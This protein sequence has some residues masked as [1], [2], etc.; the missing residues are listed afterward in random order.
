MENKVY[1]ALDICNL[2]LAMLGESPID[3]IDPNG[4]RSQRLCYTHYHPA[5]REVLLYTHLWSFAEHEVEITSDDETG[6]KGHSIPID[7]LRILKVNAPDWFLMDCA[8]Q[9][10]EKTI[11]LTYI[12]DEEDVEKFEDA[13][14]E[15]FVIRLAMK[16][17]IPLTASTKIYQELSNKYHELSNNH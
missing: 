17:C 2:A 12:A 14:V 16:L 13:F 7:T 10:S 6:I 1:T 9:S 8:I 3:G 11:K 5:R 15:M 4:C